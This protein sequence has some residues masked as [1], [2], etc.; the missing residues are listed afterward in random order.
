MVAVAPI[1]ASYLNALLLLSAWYFLDPPK[2]YYPCLL[3]AKKRYFGYMY[4]ALDQKEP[5]FDAKGIET[6][7][8]DTCQAVAKVAW[9]KPLSLETC[10]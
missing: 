5:I 4:E 7:R 3:Q 1:E 8:R 6:V 10:R 2:V 9:L